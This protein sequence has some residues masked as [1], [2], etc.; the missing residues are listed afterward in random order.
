MREIH[1]TFV[2]KTDKED[3]C[4]EGE[5]EDGLEY[6]LEGVGH[7][8]GCEDTIFSIDLIRTVKS[9]GLS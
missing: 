6:V 4:F 8:K 1:Y 2:Y 7:I 9:D 5:F 3:E